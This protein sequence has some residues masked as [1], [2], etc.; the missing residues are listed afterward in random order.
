MRLQIPAPLAKQ[1]LTFLPN[2]VCSFRWF[3]FLTPLIATRLSQE[4]GQRLMSDYFTCCNTEEEPGDHYICL[5]W[6][7]YT[8]TDPTSRERHM[9]PTHNL[10]IRIRALYPL[11]YCASNLLF[12]SAL[13]RKRSLCQPLSK[14]L[15]KQDTLLSKIDLR[16]RVE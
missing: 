14:W 16:R 3:G 13:V 8:D 11:S 7:Q 1:I 6:S 15:V 5:S 12:R 4:R 10:V 2:Q 9:V